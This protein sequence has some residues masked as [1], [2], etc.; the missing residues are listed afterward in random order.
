M[1]TSEF[2]PHSIQSSETTSITHIIDICNYGTLTKLLGVT[3]YIFKFIVDCRRQYGTLTKLLGV[4]A[5]IFKF[6]VDCRRQHQ[7]RLTGPLTLSELHNAQTRWVSQSQKEVYDNEMNNIRSHSSSIKKIPLIRQLRLLLDKD[8]LIHCGGRIHNAPLSA[9][10]NV[11]CWHQHHLN[12]N[13]STILDSNS[14][15]MSQISTTLLQHMP[16]TWWEALCSS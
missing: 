11:S 13:T 4:T 6:I 10:S 12:S 7:D 3:A 9:S 15:T 1:T 2:N 8:G 14:Q 16:E 5:Y